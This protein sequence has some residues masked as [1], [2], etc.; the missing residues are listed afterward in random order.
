MVFFM[1]VLQRE[2]T[3]VREPTPKEVGP[4]TSTRP[5]SPTRKTSFQEDISEGGGAFVSSLKSNKAPQ[6]PVATSA[7]GAEDSA[8]LTDLS[9]K[10]D[11]SAT[12]EQDIDLDALHKLASTSLGGDSTVEAAYTI[13]KASQDAHASSNAGHA[14][15]EVLADTMPFRRTRTTRRRLRK[16]V[17]SSA[18]EHFQ[19]NISAVEDTISAGDGIHAAAQTI[20]AGST[21]IPSSGGVSVGSSMDP[22][23]H[24]VAAASLSTI[25]AAGKGKAP[26]ID[27][28]LPAD[29][30]SEQERILKNLHD[31]QLGEDLAKKL[32]PNRKQRLSSER[33]R[34]L[35]AAQLI[36]NKAD[37]LELMAKIATN[38][39]LSKQ[40]LGDD[41][42]EDN[43]N[44]RLEMLFMRKR[45]ELAERSWV[46]ALSIAQL[47]H[48]FEYIQRTLERSNLLN[49]KRTTFRPTPSLEA[50]SAK[51]ARQG[52]PQDVHA[53]SSQVPTA[54]SVAADVSVPAISP[55]HATGSAHVD[56][57]VHVAE[58]NP[59]DNP[60]TSEQV[61]A[62]HTIAV[63][64]PSSS[65]TRRK[66]I[67]K[68]RV[69]LIVDIVD[70]AL[71]KFDSASD[72]DDDPLPYAPYAGW[73][74]VPSL[75]GSTYDYYDMEGHTKHFTSLRELLHMVEKNDLRKLLG[76]VNNI[77]QR[78]EPDTFS[79]LLWGDLHVLFQSLDDEDAYDFWLNHDSWRIR[80]WRLYPRAQEV[81]RRHLEALELKGGDEDTC[82]GLGCLLEFDIEI[83]DKKGAENLAADHISRHENPNLGKLTKAEIRDVFP[84]ERL[85]AVS[86]KN[87]KPCVL[88]ESYEGVWPEMR[89]QKSFD[90]VTEDHLEDIMASPPLQEKS[91]KPGFIGYISFAM[92]INELDE[93]R[94]DAYESSI[95]YKERTKRWH[96]KRIKAPTNYEKGD[97]VDHF[98]AISEEKVMVKMVD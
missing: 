49:F 7:G 22:A 66:Q 46:K 14:A 57:E 35:D 64:T 60:T 40:L 86:D 90:N 15:D 89:H 82:E 28:S 12:K 20:P 62:E 19:E 52:V 3:P 2:P 92:H 58:S 18:F 93:M 67:A 70:D 29:L 56:T 48:K 96:D 13:Y 85:M 95:S 87:N 36:Y 51:R 81:K 94:L 97:K 80:S 71:I 79:L 54:P 38:S 5:P 55:D 32:Q 88:T 43:M 68:K 73:E 16:T 41:V 25:L 83:H 63:S 91:L 53:A 69:T 17:T 65:C 44:E 50:P 42:T 31:Y 77:Y 21:P 1:W 84:E 37:W 9:L 6:T 11:R 30:L 10:L 45:R 61:S 47:K 98:V 72:S 8:A 27:D 26:M 59:N 74:M 34:E 23:G 4:T 75:L 78:E 76:A 33:Q 39:T 24:T